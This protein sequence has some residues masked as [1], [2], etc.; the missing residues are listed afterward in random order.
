MDWSLCKYEREWDGNISGVLLMIF[1]F[2]VSSGTW[3]EIKF[4]TKRDDNSSETHDKKIITIIQII[5][6]E[7]VC[8]LTKSI[9]EGR[10]ARTI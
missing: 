10:D 1:A 4:G 7:I 9:Y 2:F 5:Q 3:V 6:Y 8:N